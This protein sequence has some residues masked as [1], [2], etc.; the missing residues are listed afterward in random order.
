MA[1]RL[2]RDPQPGG[3]G[4]AHGGGHVGG[5]LRDDDRG[6]S[7]VDVEG[8]GGSRLVVARVAGR[9]DGAP[10]GGSEVAGQ[11]A[12]RGE[13][14]HPPRVVGR[15]PGDQRGGPR[16]GVREAVAGA[17][18]AAFGSGRPCRR[19]TPPRRS[20]AEVGQPRTPRGRDGRAGDVDE[21]VRARRRRPAP[22]GASRLR[23]EV[24][25]LAAV[26]GRAGGDDVVPVRRAALG[27]RDDVVDGEVRLR[28]A[29]LA[30]PSVAR[31]DRAAG[32]LAPV[33]VARDADVRHEADHD[34]AGH[35]RVLGPQLP[36][37]VLEHLGLGLEQQHRGAAHGADVDRLEGRVEDEHP[38]SS[39]SARP[40]LG[41]RRG[42]YVAWWRRAP[43][44]ALGGECTRD[45][46]GRARQD[47]AG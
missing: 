28:A 31:E 38:A 26:A 17:P 3:R 45:G 34:R 44:G 8:V 7:L 2:R 35:R 39:T 20:L 43:H 29:V 41:D 46:Y 25:A 21:D 42:P 24:V 23:R 30:R 14:R 11:R 19:P 4:G 1:A 22:A 12:G 32:D 6:G 27:A 37:R 16:R 36:R 33:G 40:V 13:G 15:R 18:S 47:A 5:V 9:D 10:H